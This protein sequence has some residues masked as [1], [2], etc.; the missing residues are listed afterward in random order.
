[1]YNTTQKLHTFLSVLFCV[2]AISLS[3]QTINLKL[4]VYLEGALINSFETTTDGLPLMRDDLR[5]NPHNFQRLIPDQDI[6]QTINVVNSYTNVDVTSKFT[7]V[8]CGAF[9]QYQTIPNPFGVFDVTGQDAI[10]DWIFVELRDKNDFTSVIATRSG[11]VQRDGDVV[12]LDGVSALAF[13]QVPNDAYFVIIRHRNHLGVMTSL[14]IPYENLIEDLDFRTYN[15]VSTYDFGNSNNQ[16]NYTGLSMKSMFVNGEEYRALW[17][18]DFDAD[19]LVSYNADVSDLNVLQMEVAGFD[20]SQ[21][22]QYRVS[23]TNSVGYLQ[24]DY[25]MDGRSKFNFPDDDRNLILNQVLSYPQNDDVRTNFGHLIE[26][27]PN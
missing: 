8:A 17:G 27:I 12:D 11:L 26:Q 2:L 4:K 22:P 7:H 16:T 15:G 23:F 19:G 20:L 24:G 1:M 14:P 6:Y 13:P 5:Q 3:G 21:N 9:P 10:V 18:G 25:D